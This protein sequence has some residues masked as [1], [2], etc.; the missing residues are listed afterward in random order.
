MC[1]HEQDQTW[2]TTLTSTELY[3][4]AFLIA[5]CVPTA[6]KNL[7]SSHFVIVVAYNWKTDWASVS[8][9]HDLHSAKNV[10]TGLL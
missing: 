3:V 9:T 6:T 8:P 4:N 7:E 2:F 10:K 1:L 5:L